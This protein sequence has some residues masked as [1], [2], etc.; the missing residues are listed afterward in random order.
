MRIGGYTVVAD[1]FRP[2]FFGGHFVGSVRLDE[3]EHDLAFDGQFGSIIE[4]WQDA[5]GTGDYAEFALHVWADGAVYLAAVALDSGDW[6]WA[7]FAGDA[8]GQLMHLLVSK[9]DLDI[10]AMKDLF[11]HCPVFTR[12]WVVEANGDAVVV[13]PVGRARPAD[14]AFLRLMTWGRQDADESG[15]AFFCVKP[16]GRQ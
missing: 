14:F 4:Y 15:L 11:V 12:D 6:V 10:P 9:P 8:F 16:G 7:N 1:S 2:P 13:S 3:R 5:D